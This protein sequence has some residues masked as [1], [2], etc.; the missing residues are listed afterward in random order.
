VIT[1]QA[2][3]G[4]KLVIKE[5]HYQAAEQIAK[6]IIPAIKQSNSR[7]TISIA[8]ESGSGKS[9][10]AQALS[11]K[12]NEQ[13][14]SAVIL[15]QDDYFVYPPLT[16]HRTRKADINWVGMQEVKLELMDSHLKK[17]IEG[18][19][20]LEKPLVNYQE[21]CIG[22]EDLSLKNIKAVI[23]EGTYTTSLENV[24][25]RVFIDLTYKETKKSRLERAREEQDDF[26]ERVL[27]I[28][29]KIISAHKD[30]ADI[31]INSVFSV[32]VRSE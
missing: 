6:R 11:E 19:E 9:E 13:E 14:I 2:M 23:A 26:L 28:E 3:I 4:D 7:Y 30:R 10:T 32:T 27:I 24:H 25:T 5:K 16:N 12:L 20:V 18:E 29:H 8:G 15:Q 21:D 17:A 31:I 1:E 22:R